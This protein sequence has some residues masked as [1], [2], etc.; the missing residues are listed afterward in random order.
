[1]KRKVIA[2][3]LVVAMIMSLTACRSSS[4]QSKGSSGNVAPTTSEGEELEDVTL[5]VFMDLGSTLSSGIQ[6]DPVAE[7]IKE[8]TGVTLNLE[9]FDNQKESVM[10][11]SGDL[12]DV[13]IIDQP[14]YIPPL[15]SSGSVADL[16][17]WIQYA[18]NVT[19]SSQAS[20]KYSKEFLSDESGKLFVLP[21]RTK[22]EAVPSARDMDGNFVRWDHYVEAGSPA[23]NS[24]DDLLDLLET[25]QKNHP[26]T[27]SGQKTYAVSQ[28]SDWGRGS[29]ESQLSKYLG[30][31]GIPLFSSYDTDDLE[32]HDLFD[33]ENLYLAYAKYMFNANQRGILDPEAFIQRHEDY[34]AKL[35]DGRVL[36]TM[37]QWEINGINNELVNS[38]KAGFVDIPFADTKE[39]PAKI[40]CV[41]PFGYRQRL[42]V[43]SSKCDDKKMRAIMRLIDFVYSEK[44]ARTIVNGPEGITWEIDDKGVANFTEETLKAQ[45]ADPT[46]LSTQGAK[47][48]QGIIGL[49][50]DLYDSTGKRFYDLTLNSDYIKDALNDY[51]K[52]YCKFYGIDVPLD[53]MTERKNQSV[54]NRAYEMLMPSEHPTDISRSTTSI[55]AYMEQQLPGLIMSK[56]QE[57][58]DVKL[59]EIREKLKSMDYDTTNAYYREA[60]KNAV[61]TYDKLMK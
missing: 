25:I 16:S 14:A 32:Y 40:K 28:W 38:G 49:D 34:N 54:D 33:D 17:D 53:V 51:E 50:Y 48:Y 13:T 15:I 59:A 52:E 31:T 3:V 37:Y 12:Y 60:F 11:A 6:S 44:G 21:M 55:E 45:R 20:L 5:N 56:N 2:I 23:I 8:K 10:V 42:L 57:E 4:N 19:E 36:S 27:D 47:Y 35:Q 24:I 46:Y 29:F 61:V 1:M 26:E 9:G 43:V 30:K 7:Y 41:A 22:A 58:Y 39:Y 18:P